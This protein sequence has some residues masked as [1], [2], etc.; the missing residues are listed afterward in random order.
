VV[1]RDWGYTYSTTSG[2]THST[3]NLA[4]PKA[5][6]DSSYYTYFAMPVPVPVH[7]IPVIPVP[8]MP[9]MPTKC[10]TSMDSE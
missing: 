4:L 6:L 8:I 2:Y 9:I 7:I 10:Y 3:T 5:S 1:L